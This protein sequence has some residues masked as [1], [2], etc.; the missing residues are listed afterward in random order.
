MDDDFLIECIEN[1]I[2]SSNYDFK[3]D[4]YDFEIQESKEDFLTDVISFANSHA[5]GSKYIITGVKLYK[6]KPRDIKGIN[7]QKIKDGADYQSLVNDN[8]EPNII[9]D[10]KTIDYKGSKFGIFKIDFTNND[11]P[12]LLSKQYGKLP[13]GYIRIRKGQKNEYISRRDFDIFYKEKDTAKYS[14]INLKGILNR[15]ISD[16]FEIKKYENPI[17]LKKAKET[18]EKLFN[19]LNSIELIKSS[20]STIKMGL[21][22]SIQQQDI[23]IIQKY[24]KENHISLQK[25][26]F[27]IGNL[28]YFSIPYSATQYYGTETEKKKYKLIDKL[29][30]TISI[31]EGFMDFYGKISKIF[32]TEL[33][34][35]NTGKQFDEDIEVTLKIKAK[36]LYNLDDFPIPSESIIEIINDND[37]IK[38][39]LSIDKNYGINDYTSI[40]FRPI[41]VMPSGVNIPTIGYSKPSYDSYV[42]YFKEN[43]KSIVDYE[44]I[45][46]GEYCFIRYEQKNIKPNEDISL[47]ARI[48]FSNELDEIEYEIRT[49]FNPNIQKGR[50]LKS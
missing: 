48:L 34:I 29:S 12:Y 2:E 45:I 4:I 44:F 21:E 35:K 20:K 42:E 47:P 38:K 15:K 50:I 41:P 11:Q 31:F 33:A 30:E 7:E 5:N 27:D 1:E 14:N 24:A 16:T 19:E 22:V 49:K 8:I 46:E 36:S 37:I 18:I 32:Y 10:F 23:D 9:I 43:L 39:Y 17:D 26:F 25:D 6:D 13:K 28:T 40:G 3:K